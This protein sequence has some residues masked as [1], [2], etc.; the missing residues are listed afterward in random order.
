M[1]VESSREDGRR[2]GR[3]LRKEHDFRRSEQAVKGLFTRHYDK[4]RMQ[5]TSGQPNWG[6][7][8]DAYK[9]GFMEGY[10]DV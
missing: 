9:A 10:F 5:K 1:T 4:P 6:A 3:A 8:L 2:D 7:A